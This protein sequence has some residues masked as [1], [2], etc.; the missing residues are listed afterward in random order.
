MASVADRDLPDAEVAACVARAYTSMS[1]PKPEG[2][3][4]TVV[5]PV[6]FG[7]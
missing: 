4:V 6:V 5:Y 3:I 1:F 7:S 2:G